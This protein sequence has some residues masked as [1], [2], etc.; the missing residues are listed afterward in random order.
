MKWCAEQEALAS[1][2]MGKRPRATSA[3]RV[4]LEGLGRHTSGDAVVIPFATPVVIPFAAPV[5]IPCRH[6]LGQASSTA[7]TIRSSAQTPTSQAKPAIGPMAIM[8]ASGMISWSQ[9]TGLAFPS[10]LPILQGPTNV[11]RECQVQ[12]FKEGIFLQ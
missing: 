2:Q 5:V 4:R 11:L 1:R 10:H 6:T 8:W 7:E 3:T 9:M 12:F